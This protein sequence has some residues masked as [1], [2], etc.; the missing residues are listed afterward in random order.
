MRRRRTKVCRWCFQPLA[1]WTDIWP[2]RP[3]VYLFYGYPHNKEIDEH[4]RH[5]LVTVESVGYI[6][7]VVY[8]TPR[9]TL[10]KS[11]G[12]VGFFMPVMVP[13]EAP[14]QSDLDAMAEEASEKAK[15]IKAVRL[16]KH[17]SRRL[18]P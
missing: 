14:A 5:V 18:K 15:K 10:K 8:R 17:L 4:P 11:T 2:T 1:E 12:A 13:A 6:F 16:K 3:G 9:S 7:G